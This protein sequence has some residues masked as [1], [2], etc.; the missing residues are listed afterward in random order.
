MLLPDSRPDLDLAGLVQAYAYPEACRQGRPFVKA[1]MV[2]SLDGA[3]AGTDDSSRSLATPA[4]RRVFALLRGLA[5]VLLV[6][7]G[8][9]RAERYRPTL[10]PGGVTGRRIAQRQSPSAAVAVVSRSL[11]L[12]ERGPLFTDPARQTVVVTC[13]AAP[14]SRRRALSALVDVVVAGDAQVDLTAAVGALA[15]RG[16]PRILCEGGPSLLGAVAAA[17][18]LDELCLTWVP[19]VAGG[20]AGRVVDAPPLGLAM[21]L[22]HLLEERGTLLARWAHD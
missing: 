9:A 3:V 8:T 7:G 19:V 4:D 14:G 11:D 13:E 10:P 12:D 22:A 1:T 17:G 20:P 15:A 2:A 5:D 6:G 18:L 21:R 16:L